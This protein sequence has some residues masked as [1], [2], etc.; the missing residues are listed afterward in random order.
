MVANAFCTTQRLFLHGRLGKAERPGVG[1]HL[2]SVQRSSLDLH[3]RR[4]RYSRGLT[5]SPERAQSYPGFPFRD[6]LHL[7]TLRYRRAIPT[8]QP[9]G[10]GTPPRRPR[11][12]AMA[13]S[14]GHP[15]FYSGKGPRFMT[16]PAEKVELKA[17]TVLLFSI[18]SFGGGA[19]TRGR[20]GARRLGLS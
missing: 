12:G 9:P 7:R 6:R 11:P 16:Q 15:A 10:R 14:A 8:L 20:P 19:R 4:R 3:P 18:A 5:R 1:R 2:W 13:I 17:E